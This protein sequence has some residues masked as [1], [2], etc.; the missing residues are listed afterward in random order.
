M[1]FYELS[2][3]IK[4]DLSE[5]EL[6]SLFEQISSFIQERGGV[7]DKGFKEKKMTLGYPIKEEGTAFLKNQNF[8]LKPE[9]LKD[10]KKKLKE[11]KEILRSIILTKKVKKITPKKPAKMKISKSKR[12]A[13]VELKDIEKKLEEILEE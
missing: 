12:K 9:K 3:L 4:P 1:R 13:K 7:L 2:C 11:K 6:K 10:L 8:Y 5:E